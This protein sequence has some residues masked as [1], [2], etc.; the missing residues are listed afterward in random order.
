M[1]GIGG[2]GAAAR[3]DSQIRVIAESEKRGYEK[4]RKKKRK[5]KEFLTFNYG[6]FTSEF[7]ELFKSYF[8]S[9]KH[10]CKEGKLMDRRFL[11]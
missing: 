9:A 4:M 10:H 6:Q 3:C 2:R 8:F 7:C 11:G 5:E 1:G